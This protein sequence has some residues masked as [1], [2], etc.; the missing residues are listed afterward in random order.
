[1]AIRK[2]SGA[3]QN[4]TDRISWAVLAPAPVDQLRGWLLRDAEETPLAFLTGSEQYNAIVDYR[5]GSEGAD[6][7]TAEAVS[8]SLQGDVYMLRFTE[9]LDLVW[10][11]RHGRKSRETGDNPWTVARSL[12][13]PLPGEPPPA[14]ITRSVCVVEGHT[15][16]EVA[17]ALGLP[18]PPTSGPMHIEPCASGA[19]F[20]S[21]AGNVAVFQHQISAALQ[22]TTCLA[23]SRDAG[24]EFF[25]SVAENGKTA[26][27]F[28]T[29]VFRAAG[30]V[31][32]DSI[33][34]EQDPHR[35][36]AAL[37]I[38]PDLLDLK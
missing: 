26:G 12:G 31:R 17:K 37:G 1:M 4:S 11:Y 7:S 21:D 6:Q 16:S 25:C 36:A 38:R 8:R 13:C 29:P 28:E 5:P 10:I 22:A 14:P 33:K 24:R 35:I 34:G 2:R 23:A 20:Y 27:I 3:K 32:L 19:L 9:D 30:T 18:G 15:P